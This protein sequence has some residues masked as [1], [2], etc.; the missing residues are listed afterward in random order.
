LGAR[1]MVSALF[2]REE[3]RVLD[4]LTRL[5]GL[6]AGSAILQAQGRREI[7]TK[8]TRRIV[9]QTSA[10]WNRMASWAPILEQ[11]D[12]AA[13]VYWPSSLCLIYKTAKGA[14]ELSRLSRKG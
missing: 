5:V 2:E 12:L 3:R 13:F 7:A 14:R 11:L 1:V 9:D 10:I 6:V 8:M 4:S